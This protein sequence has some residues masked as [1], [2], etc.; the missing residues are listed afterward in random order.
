MLEVL[1]SEYIKLAKAKGL[2][3]RVVIWKHALRNG[4]IPVVTFAG[5]SLVGLLNGSVAIE[6][7]FAWPG[8]GRLIYQGI[9]G[10]DYPLVQGSL[11]L[12]GFMVVVM[13]V[14]VDILYSRIDPRIRLA[15]AA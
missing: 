10:R 12:V 5:I 3:Q 2:P 14:L 11:L 4:L 6:A 13:S 9:V 7:V 1:D 15:S 8:V